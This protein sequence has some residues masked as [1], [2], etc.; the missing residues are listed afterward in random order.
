MTRILNSELALQAYSLNFV[1]DMNDA[2]RNDPEEV[3]MYI[4]GGTAYA[5]WLNNAVKDISAELVNQF[6]DGIKDMLYVK[7]DI[8]TNIGAKSLAQFDR[9][10]GRFNRSFDNKREADLVS[11]TYLPCLKTYVTNVGTWLRNT[12]NTYT[13]D[14]MTYTFQ[15]IQSVK[16]YR[17]DMPFALYRLLAVYYCEANGLF[18]IAELVD[19]SVVKTY[20]RMATTMKTIPI[21]LKHLWYKTG[22][23]YARKDDGKPP[24]QLHIMTIRSVFEDLELMIRDQNPAAEP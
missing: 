9:L 11:E 17:D 12:M 5:L 21:Q 1:K 8:D 18:I 20:N 24:L 4:K 14:G 2:L 10:H 3:K 13:S 15:Q 7:S 23:V 16:I 22:D 6:P 19:I